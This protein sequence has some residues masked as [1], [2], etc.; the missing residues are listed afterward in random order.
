MGIRARGINWLYVA[1]VF[2]VG[3]SI[4][5]IYTLGW[6]RLFKFFTGDKDLNQIGDFL[7]GAFAPIALIWLVAAV[8]TQRQEL[9]ET[10]DQFSENQKVVDEQLKTIR[11]QNILLNQQAI[12]ARE[13]AKQA[14]KLNLY[15]KRMDIYQRFIAFGEKH[16]SR[17]K[18]YNDQSYMDMRNLA[19]EAAFVFDSS[20]EEW[21][22]KIAQHIYDYTQFKGDYHTRYP[23][24][25]SNQEFERRRAKRVGWLED[26]FLPE[27]R[28]NKFWSFMHVSDQPHMPG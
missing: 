5:L 4:W 8:L 25:P 21:F 3:Y 22:E 12:D 19:H 15:D 7:A 2:T 20:L 24:D 28:I 14:Y 1:M 16:A 23:D 13:N 6:Q 18:D 11:S 27:E 17:A 26:Q 9:T 10:R